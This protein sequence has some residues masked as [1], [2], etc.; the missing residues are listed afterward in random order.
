[1]ALAFGGQGLNSLAIAPCYFEKTIE[2][3]AAER[4]GLFVDCTVGLVAGIAKQ[5][6]K[7]LP[8]RKCWESIATKKLSGWRDSD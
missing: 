1:M 6:C 7:R 2:L 4:G 3:L 8:T 5:F